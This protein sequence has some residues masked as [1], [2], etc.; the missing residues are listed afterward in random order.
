MPIKQSITPT[1][2]NS[3]GSRFQFPTHSEN[4]FFKVVDRRKIKVVKD[5]ISP[6]GHVNRA[7]KNFNKSQFERTQ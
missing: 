1:A 3:L 5:N 6:E 2:E 7:T 4:Q